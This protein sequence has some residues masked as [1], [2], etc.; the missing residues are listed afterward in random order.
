MKNSICFLATLLLFI[1]ISVASAQVQEG[2]RPTFEQQKLIDE[3]VKLHDAGDF[4]GAI[5]KY[6][7]VL[8]ESPTNVVALYEISMSYI[9][10]GNLEKSLLF[11]NRGAVLESNMRPDFYMLI[12]SID[13]DLGHS[14]E[15]IIAYKHGIE[16]APDN[17]ML[18]FN[19]GVT[20]ARIG[21]LQLARESFVRSAQLDPNHPGT[22]NALAV[23]Y[24]QRGQRIPAILASARLLMLESGTERAA[25]KVS[26]INRSIGNLAAID[27]NGSIVLNMGSQPDT[28]EGNF[29]AAELM[30][31]MLISTR[32]KM[33]GSEMIR[34]PLAM[35]MMVLTTVMS[36]V[37]GLADKKGSSK[38]FAMEYYVPYLA[39][40]VKEGHLETFCYYILRDADI[41]GV[42]EWL[43][44]HSDDVT[45]LV[46][47]SKFYKWPEGKE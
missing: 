6:Q 34:K 36:Q 9:E 47:W 35:R 19:L 31:P 41:E 18:H 28:S 20:Y 37:A 27:S 10:A 46:N 14:T 38:G 26:I 32:M 17:Q 42:P 30:I 1:I 40:L 24:D 22:H 13:D 29:T 4:N 43:K 11:A 3:G 25:N 8:D 5:A 12:G 39:A 23:I 45:R 15:A 21:E 44:K 7:Q 2:V 33:G 16:S